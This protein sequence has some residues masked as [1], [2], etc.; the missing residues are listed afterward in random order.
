MKKRTA[1]QKQTPGAS[2]SSGRSSS[3][4]VPI[5]FAFVL[6]FLTHAVILKY[7]PTLLDE[8]EPLYFFSVTCGGY[9]MFT[10]RI[11]LAAVECD[12]AGELQSL[13]IYSIPSQPKLGRSIYVD[14]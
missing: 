3:N 9:A 5:S 1:R 4:E 13:V 7:G 11:R 10:D 14:P 8:K 12:L 6:T 2:P